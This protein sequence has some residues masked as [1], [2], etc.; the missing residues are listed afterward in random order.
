MIRIEGLSKSFGGKPVLRD[1]SLE[2][3][4][5]E[6]FVLLGRSGCGKTT[7]L[8]CIAGFERPDAGSIFIEGRAV[9]SLPVER[10]PIGFIFQRHALF[11]HKTVYDNIAVGPRIRGEAEQ[12]IQ[13]KIDALLAITRLTG[14]RHAWP[15]QL[16]G[17]ESQRVAL[18]RA[19][20]NRPKVLLLDE[21]LSALDA[22]LRQNLRDELVEMQ[23]A[24]G[25]TF[26]FVT[27]D[28]EEAMSL[29]DRMSILEDGQLLQVGA[30]E[31]LYDRPA[32]RFVAEFL[33]GVNRLPGVVK[34]EAASGCRVTLDD[35]LQ[36]LAGGELRFPVG[37]PVDVFFRP[38]RAGLADE[39]GT[40]TGMN[41]VEGVL[42]HKAFYGSHTRYRV[43]LLHG[44]AVT[45]Q[46]R[47]GID[48]GLRVGMRVWVEVAIED[49]LLYQREK[50][51]ENDA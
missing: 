44:P 42:E 47:H 26:L 27:H 19:V 37:T 4:E 9:N 40:R 48:A 28:Q 39:P 51:N 8:R 11:P 10:R 2:I 38:E 20:I 25:I 49:T 29:A 3:G 46:V 23:K 21:P 34:S 33:G 32:D 36:L 17:G 22:S 30:P 13:D 1:F 43:R 16:S 12:D 50:G 45:V 18:A 7:L 31:Q 24:F 6:R 41:R 5:G 15:N 14:L 35:S